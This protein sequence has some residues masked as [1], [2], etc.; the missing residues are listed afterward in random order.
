[1]RPLASLPR[2]APSFSVWA[3]AAMSSCDSASSSARLHSSAADALL[4]LPEKRRNNAV[5]TSARITKAAST[6]ISEN[7]ALRFCFILIQDCHAAGQ[8]V[9]VDFEFALAGCNGD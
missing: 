6:S 7:P 5:A 2:S 1:M 3:E 9:D 8:P 4:R